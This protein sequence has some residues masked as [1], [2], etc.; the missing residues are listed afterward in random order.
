MLTGCTEEADEAA[1]VGPSPSVADD[2]WCPMWSVTENAPV[3]Y[4][5]ERHVYEQ[6]ASYTQPDRLHEEVLE[7]DSPLAAHAAAHT[8][9]A[10]FVLLGDQNA[11]KSTL[12]HAFAHARADGHLSLTSYLPL[13]SASFRNV[14]LLP[15]ATQG[16]QPASSMPPEAHAPP[17][18][19][20]VPPFLDTDIGE[21]SL[22]MTREDFLFFLDEFN[23]DPTSLPV[24]SRYVAIQFLEIGGDHL[25][26]LMCP[27][28]EALSEEH[29]RMA[30]RSRSLLDAAQKTVYF[31]NARSIVDC[32][33]QLID[34][35]GFALLLARMRWLSSVFA[36]SIESH[37]ILLYASHLPPLWKGSDCSS[38]VTLP[39]SSSSSAVDVSAPSSSACSSCT[40]HSSLREFLKPFAA[41]MW[42]VLR[43][44][45]PVSET[46]PEPQQGAAEP[47][48]ERTTDVWLDSVIQNPRL[49]LIHPIALLLETVLIYCKHREEW[50]LSFSEIYST[51]HVDPL[52][53][54]LIAEEIVQTVVRLFQRNMHVTQSL[55]PIVV[56]RILSAEQDLFGN[57]PAFE[58]SAA[59]SLSSL[60]DL[61]EDS[62]EYRIAVWLDQVHFADFLDKSHDAEVPAPL[63][64]QGFNPVGEQLVRCG[65]ALRYGCELHSALVVCFVVHRS[66]EGDSSTAVPSRHYWDPRRL[67]SSLYL[68]TGSTLASPSPDGVRPLSGSAVPDR[69]TTSWVAIEQHSF[70]DTPPWPVRSS[71]S[72]PQ[73]RSLRKHHETRRDPTRDLEAEGGGRNARLIRLPSEHRHSDAD[74]RVV[75][76]SDLSRPKSGSN[77]SPME[78]ATDHQPHSQHSRH[79]HSHHSPHLDHSQRSPERHTHLADD[80][81]TLRLRLPQFS[82]TLRNAVRLHLSAPV[83]TECWMSDSDP[84]HLPQP[85]SKVAR[86]TLP[87][88]PSLL[89]ALAELQSG[90]ERVFAQLARSS[91]EAG[92]MPLHEARRAALPMLHR[93]F[94]LLEE[95]SLALGLAPASSARSSLSLELRLSNLH[96]TR[97]ATLFNLS[98]DT[99]FAPYSPPGVLEV[100]LHTYTATQT[101]DEPQL[102]EQAVLERKGEVH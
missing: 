77:P 54:T 58:R 5:P 85:R 95:Y 44:E 46:E 6:R 35:A 14:R 64:L 47:L 98:S 31:V 51:N 72:P 102:V 99:P 84:A 39:S 90:I 65:L 96:W 38:N 3:R 45:S 43:S 26:L 70:S 36:N 78:E 52:N 13:L 93:L 101:T 63:L 41:Q 19:M 17:L 42:S 33:A 81:Q 23:L 4:I 20:D 24:D 56:S 68:G 16:V 60:P 27:E 57:A 22:L 91:T 28:R 32:A 62:D 69:T 59:P 9:A 30:S 2:R 21:A 10:R 92:G 79:A 40:S 53:N 61:I 25:D 18:P 76:Q 15:D 74:A 12:L 50:H 87:D 97:L 86:S 83:P 67:E 88:R 55:T 1:N 49:H 29:L 37:Q 71:S 80:P 94:W 11:G 73:H 66:P 34:R 75:L 8:W 82:R 100:H 48:L 89:Q 7:I